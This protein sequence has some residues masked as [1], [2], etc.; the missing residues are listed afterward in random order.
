M[1]FVFFGSNYVVFSGIEVSDESWPIQFKDNNLNNKKRKSQP[2][3]MKMK[4]ENYLKKIFFA[5]NG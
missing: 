5:L 4:S 1:Y 2:V 3:N